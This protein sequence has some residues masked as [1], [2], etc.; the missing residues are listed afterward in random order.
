MKSSDGIEQRNESDE[1]KSH[2]VKRDYDYTHS[3]QFKIH[4]LNVA[5]RNNINKRHIVI[6]QLE[7]VVLTL[8]RERAN[9]DYFE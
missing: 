2:N 4:N 5:Q 1:K 9:K 6:K 7:M 3:A 8:K